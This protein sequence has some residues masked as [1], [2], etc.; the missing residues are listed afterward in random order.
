MS[1][2]PAGGMAKAAPDATEAATPPPVL[3]PYQ[4]AIVEAPE[5]VV[6][7]EK[8]RRTGATWGVG[9]LSAMTSAAARAHGGMD[10]LYIGP[11][12]DMAREF[13]DAAAMWVRALMGFAAAI[14]D[15]DFEELIGDERRAIKAFRIDLP[16]GFTILALSSRPRSLRGRQGLVIID[17]A[18]FHD[19]LFEILKAALALLVWGG[20]VI[21]I[22][23]HDGVENAF[24]ELCQ[25]VREGRRPWGL[26]RIP[27][28]EAVVQGLYRRIC[29]VQGRAWSQEAEDAWV[30]D[31][32]A[33]YGEGAAE[34]LDCIPRR[35]A[36]AYLSREVIEACMLGPD[37]GGGHVARLTC[38]PGFDLRPMAERQAHV[39]RWLDE[40]VRPALARLDP[41][42]RTAIGED[43]GRTVDLT[44]IALGQERR[45][46]T[47]D[48]GLVVELAQ[49]PLAQQQQVLAC[50]ADAAPRLGAVHLDATGNGLGLAE[51]AAE[52]WGQS[53]VTGVKISDGWY[54]DTAPRLKGRLEDRK[55]LLPLD[56]DLRDDL[57]ALRVVA[58][59]P[60][61]PRDAR[62]RGRHGDAAVALLMLA[63]A[64]RAETWEAGYETAAP[65]RRRVDDV[66]P[67]GDTDF[68]GDGG[69]GAAVTLGRSLGRSLGG[70][71]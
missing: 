27:F 25:D 10:T 36:G 22:S 58:G 14:Q 18:A 66:G 17:E 5:A 41:A 49:C 53:R 59:V 70:S 46:L 31:I 13:I 63:A 26:I 30:A 4:R 38:P 3:L 55:I 52:R 40:A 23:T 35:S 19:H 12:Q 48:V 57:R 50:L 69:R 56:R 45:D 16:S 61:V 62:A 51:W 15:S 7:V 71:W 37:E 54:L 47:L 67:G 1:R 60:K 65:V 8:G 29:L 21:L 28:R 2:A 20:R 34:E 39:E 6:V 33:Q 32:Y 42:A 68:D 11:S 24:N 43:F 44:V 64:I 9:A